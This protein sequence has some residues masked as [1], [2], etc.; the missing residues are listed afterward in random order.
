MGPAKM[1]DIFPKHPM[2]MDLWCLRRR[3]KNDPRAYLSPRLLRVC[4]GFGCATL[5]Q[6]KGHFW[7]SSVDAGSISGGGGVF[8]LD[9]FA[10]RLFDT[11]WSTI[12]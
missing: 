10:S 11:L 2:G 4:C 1:T 9:Q 8:E 12:D 3:S 7:I 5:A 6:D